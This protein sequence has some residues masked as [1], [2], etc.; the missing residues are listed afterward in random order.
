M[1]MTPTE[2]A[3]HAIASAYGIGL[4]AALDLAI[5]NQRVLRSHRINAS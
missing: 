5:R 3:L 4:E 2:M 1:T